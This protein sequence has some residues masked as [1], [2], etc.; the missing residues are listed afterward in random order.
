MLCFIR[1]LFFRFF[2]HQPRV[3]VFPKYYRQIHEHRQNEA[4]IFVLLRQNEH[5]E[6]A[7]M[8]ASEHE[9]SERTAEKQLLFFMKLTP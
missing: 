6:N 7:V 1:I 4:E 3:D 8:Y 2:I 5:I 9:Q